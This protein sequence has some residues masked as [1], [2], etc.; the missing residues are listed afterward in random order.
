MAFDIEMI[1]AVYNQ[2]DQRIDAARKILNK[3]L[4]LTEKILYSHLFDQSD[5][6]GCAEGWY[7]MLGHSKPCGLYFNKDIAHTIPE[8]LVKCLENGESE[9]DI[10]NQA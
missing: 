3:P 9:E 5:F 6:Y 2:M 1:K 7:F 4:T 8:E 10:Q